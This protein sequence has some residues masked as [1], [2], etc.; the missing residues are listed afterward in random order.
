[1]PNRASPQ[2]RL[3]L[4]SLL[5][6]AGTWTHGYGISQKT[7]LKSGTLYP[8]LMRLFERGL[9]ETHWATAEPGRPPRH[10]YRLTR[11]GARYAREQLTLIN[12]RAVRGRAVLS[13]GRAQ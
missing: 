5:E 1:M 8:L 13:E 7:G 2:T 12:T 11:D 9:V 3:V 4:Q 6:E 10:L